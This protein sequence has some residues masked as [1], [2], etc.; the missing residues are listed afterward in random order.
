M[1]RVGKKKD[2][3]E[4][5]S[6]PP[7]AS[8]TDVTTE[9]APEPAPEPLPALAI[10]QHVPLENRPLS[11]IVE[12]PVMPLNAQGIWGSETSPLAAASPLGAT[13]VTAAE[14]P[15]NVQGPDFQTEPGTESA[16]PIVAEPEAAVATEPEPAV[17][18]PVAEQ[19]KAIEP[20]AE[21][22]T[23]AGE[24]EANVDASATDALLTPNSPASP[25]C[26]LN[27]QREIARARSPR[28]PSVGP[29]GVNR[30]RAS[31]APSII[32]VKRKQP[33]EP[34]AVGKA[35]V[36]YLPGKSRRI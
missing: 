2:K 14:S 25:P 11:A 17:E 6:T 7:D 20:V 30:S 24:V 8:T 21:P 12:S 34:D 3:P 27:A 29:S 4:G 28:H 10:P 18:A 32:G 1:L 31:P 9:P 22:S 23:L 15:I 19:P 5:T 26:D 13:V 36:R 16:N 33:D 35:R